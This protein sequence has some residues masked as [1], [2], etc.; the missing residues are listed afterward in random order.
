MTISTFPRELFVIPE[1]RF[2]KLDRISKDLIFAEAGSNLA[3]LAEMSSDLSY[4]L[5]LTPKQRDVLFFCAS[6]LQNESPKFNKLELQDR[7]DLWQG[8]ILYNVDFAQFFWDIIENRKKIVNNALRMEKIF[9]KRKGDRSRVLNFS[10][11]TPEE[12]EI[13]IESNNKNRKE[14]YNSYTAEEL[15]ESDRQFACT[16][17][18]LDESRK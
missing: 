15:E 3:W 8:S 6:Q 1:L 7:L 10:S 5:N 14:R 13:V 12:R 18:L 2:D 16:F 9:E 17:E 11:I 4:W